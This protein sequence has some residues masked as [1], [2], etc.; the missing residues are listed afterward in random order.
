MKILAIDPSG[1]F[2]EGKGTTG[3]ALLDET[4]NPIACGQI[5]AEDFPTQISYWNAIVSLADNLEP[6]YIVIEDFL[7]YANKSQVQIHSRFETAKL[8]GVL[9]Y[10]F[11]D[12][13][14]TLQRAVDVKKRW[15]DDILV[16]KGYV[17]K[18]GSRYYA[19]G[20]LVSEHIRD[21]IRHGVHFITFKLN[22]NVR[23]K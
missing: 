21:A 6:D 20:V 22:K 3:W 17:T 11:K 4:C 1:N 13:N 10:Y 8:I 15:N 16:R 14:I 2:N 18:N 12:K 19:A 5:R 23:R 9:E 7:L